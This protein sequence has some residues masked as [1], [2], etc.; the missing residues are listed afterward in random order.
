MLHEGRK[1]LNLLQLHVVHSHFQMENI[2]I[3]SKAALESSLDGG[4][5]RD[6]DS[7]ARVVQ[8]TEQAMPTSAAY[9]AATSKALLGTCGAAMLSLGSLQQESLLLHISSRYGLVM[10]STCLLA[11]YAAGAHPAAYAATAASSTC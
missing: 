7:R 8:Q 11:T 9:C 6:S 5:I 2:Q 1:L 4:M 3:S 10:H